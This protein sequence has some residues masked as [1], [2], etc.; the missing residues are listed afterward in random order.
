MKFVFNPDCEPGSR[1]V[2]NS[3]IIGDGVLDLKK[4]TFDAYILRD[5]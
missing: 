4:V 5:T 2:Q 3:V 1:I